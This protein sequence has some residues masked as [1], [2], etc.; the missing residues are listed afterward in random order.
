MSKSFKL[1]HQLGT[2]RD[3]SLKE[4]D[5][6]KQKAMFVDWVRNDCSSGRGWFWCQRRQEGI[7]TPTKSSNR[8]F[9]KKMLALNLRFPTSWAFQQSMLV[10]SC[11]LGPHVW[12]FGL[13]W[14]PRL[15]IPFPFVCLFVSMARMRILTCTTTVAS[16]CR[17]SNCMHRQAQIGSRTYQEQVS[18][19]RPGDLWEGRSV[20]YSRYW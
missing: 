14:V 1:E 5:R 11:S 6:L 15:L 7:L 9:E 17:R 13:Y 8:Y 10:D 12:Y 19:S 3:L 4:V 2:F 18:G 16:P 20:W